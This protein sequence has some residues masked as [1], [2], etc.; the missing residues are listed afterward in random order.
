MNFLQI[1]GHFRQ[2]PVFST[3]DM[4]KLE[5]KLYPA[6]LTE[7]RKKNYIRKIVRNYYI[8]S[9]QEI[10]EPVLYLIA[11]SIYAPSYV[12]LETALSYYGLIPEG[13]Y[14]VTS[15][16]SRK[17]AQFGT[18][19]GNFIYRKIKPQLM[20]G[21]KMVKHGLLTYKIA[22]QEKALLDY[23]YL[24]PGLKNEKDFY[25]MRVNSEQLLASLDRKKII[26]Y[27]AVFKNKSLANRVNNFLKFHHA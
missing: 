4:R 22:D 2:F 27:L 26:A 23:F 3:S 17:T 20:F 24:N 21:F 1:K 16:S 11:N 8:F 5:L 14:S 10:N 12:S 7:W 25:E 9:D 6:R 15:I 13:I 18:P 19:V